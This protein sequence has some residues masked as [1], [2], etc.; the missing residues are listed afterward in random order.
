MPKI[1]QLIKRTSAREVIAGITKHFT[2]RK[3]FMLAGDKTSAKQLIALFQAHLDALD[4]IAAAHVALAVAV[5]EERAI[6]ARVNRTEIHLKHLM[7][8]EAPATYRDFGWLVPK[9]TGPKTVAG[10]AAGAEKARATRAAR[11]TMGSRQRKR[12]EAARSRV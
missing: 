10:K 1:S 2:G 11:G 4:K 8:N 5:S 12:S 6:A 9:K 3:T 7:S